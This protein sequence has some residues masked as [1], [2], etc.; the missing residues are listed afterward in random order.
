MIRISLGEKAMLKKAMAVVMS[1]ALAIT[2]TAATADNAEARR[3]RG[4]AIVGGIAL[5]ALALGAAGAYGRPY[6]RSGCYRGPRECRWVG[7]E[8]YWNRWGEQVCDGG[9]RKCWRPT[10]CD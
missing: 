9:Y 8:C 10:Y 1:L 2:I 3:G 7:G 6:H 5:G 4:A